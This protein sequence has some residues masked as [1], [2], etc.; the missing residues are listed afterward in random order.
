[1][2]S[3][4]F[5]RDPI[6]VPFIETPNRRIAT[7]IPAPGTVTILESLDKFE[8]RSMH[9][10]LPL[11]WHAA[12]GHTIEDHAGNRW[13][14]FTSMIFVANVGHGNSKVISRVQEAMKLPM[15]GCYAYPNELRAKYLEKLVD[16]AG[17][18]F[19]KAF[20]LSAGTETTEA[21]GNWHGRTLGAQMMSDNKSQK[22]WVGHDLQDIAH[23][24]FPY[25]WVLQDKDPKQYLFESLEK[26]KDA[27]ISL[28]EDIAGIMLET[29]QGWAAVFYP[30]EYV[31]ALREICD[32]NNILLC[33]DEMQAGFG[34]TGM[35][36]GY[37]HYEVKADLICCG[38]GMGGGFP[39][40][41][42]IGKAEVMDL[43]DIGNMSSTHSGNP[44][45]CAAG[46]AVIEEIESRDLIRESAR[47]G[48]ILHDELN[49]LKLEFKDLI[50]GVYGQ[51]LIASIVFKDPVT[52]A[53]NS[54]F[55]S[56]LAEKCMQKGL[57]VVHT[58]RESIKIGP[59]LVI[60]DEALLEGISVIHESILEILN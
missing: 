42:V 55:V 53:P 48:N 4:V 5:S 40:S 1:M 36:F 50:S 32:S 3:H 20:L 17:P 19:E 2:A 14:D 8:S 34:R 56:R 51:G 26:L 23:I 39:I 37:E 47:K 18:N 29:F 10:Q 6:V 13:I 52:G 33:F 58:G 27:G 22:S 41:G 11:I 44:V 54:E 38:K 15:L 35:R 25:P 7:A 49:N 24:D 30:K 46:L 31:Q 28:G 60:S 45:M 57:L 12:T 43:P 21:S 16:F 9:G 59:P